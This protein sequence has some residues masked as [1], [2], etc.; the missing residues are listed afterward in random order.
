MTTSYMSESAIL[1]RSG[2]SELGALEKLSLRGGERV[3]RLARLDN[4]P[5]LKAL[6]TLDVASN[7]LCTLA[8]LSAAGAPALTALDA[9]GNCLHSIDGLQ[10]LCGS[11]TDLDLTGNAIT[12]LPS[13]LGGMRRLEWLGL[14]HNQLPELRELRAL[15]PVTQLARLAIAG[16]PIAT[17]PQA[18]LFAVHC[19]RGL[20]QLDGAPVVIADVQEADGRFDTSVHDELVRELEQARARC[21]E[22]EGK[23]EAQA[24][25]QQADEAARRREVEARRQAVEQAAELRAEL[26]AER[27]RARPA[28]IQLRECRQQ[29]ASMREELYALQLEGCGGLY[30]AVSV[31]SDEA[32]G[33]VAAPSGVDAC[34]QEV[35]GLL[36]ATPPPKAAHRRAKP[37]EGA[38]DDLAHAA[39]DV[40]AAAADILDV[41]DAAKADADASD[42]ALVD[43]ATD[44][45]SWRDR[46]TTGHGDEEGGR[47]RRRRAEGSVARRLD[48]GEAASEEGSG[49]SGEEMAVASEAVVSVA[50][51]LAVGPGSEAAEA[52]AVEA[53]ATAVRPGGAGAVGD[54]A[55]P[56]AASA[57]TP[58]STASSTRG[59]AMAAED[60]AEQWEADPAE[61]LPPQPVRCPSPQQQL[62]PSSQHAGS[63]GHADEVPRR[64]SE[65]AAPSSHHAPSPQ[66]VQRLECL[67]LELQQHAADLAAELS[68]AR[69]EL[70]AEMDWTAEL[71]AGRAELAAE[72]TAAAEPTAAPPPAVA[73]PADAARAAASG[74]AGRW[75]D[76]PRGDGRWGDGRWGEAGARRE[77]GG[78]EC[79]S[80]EQ[81][82]TAAAAEGPCWPVDA[83]ERLTRSVY[84]SL[85]RS[86]AVCQTVVTLESVS[87][88]G[89][90]S[91]RACTTL[92][93]RVRVCRTRAAL[94]CLGESCPC[95]VR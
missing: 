64:P 6:R 26:D 91:S 41:A 63:S 76:G 74:D 22:L 80:G 95:P 54:A 5:S 72:L 57:S 65:G 84:L 61:A 15:R 89:C 11:L 93:V 30:G 13:W 90:Q 81:E 21:A 24:E 56:P 7:A 60:V 23:L 71:R 62:R 77:E 32:S 20:Q 14:A 37:S 67:V 43:P 85:P 27:R 66:H 8:P 78:E 75:G 50:A 33:R 38:D 3:G 42:A 29:L 44:P 87:S 25:A 55:T 16:N 17:L 82:G 70:A 92:C 68:Q 94:L 58:A 88:S 45:A 59:S 79:A 31:G 10:A 34:G 19:C 4:L 53:T 52:K 36:R 12:K 9:S 86:D 18:R 47:R 28:A 2:A 39:A 48:W 40:A 69:A 83:V 1:R 51:E 35:D 49:R 46:L 73:E